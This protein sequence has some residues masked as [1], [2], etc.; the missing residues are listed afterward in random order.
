MYFGGLDA[1]CYRLRES[2][3]SV[4]QIG[5]KL[6]IAG[7]SVQRCLARVEARRAQASNIAVE[8]GAPTADSAARLPTD[9]FVEL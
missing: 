9:D 4:R 2:G 6:D 3:L 8:T 7:A 1:E 5:R